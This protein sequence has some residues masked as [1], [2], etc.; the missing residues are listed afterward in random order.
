MRLRVSGLAL[1]WTFGCA[2]AGPRYTRVMPPPVDVPD[3]A[4]ASGWVAGEVTRW[5]P[6][7]VTTLTTSGLRGFRTLR[8][9][10]EEVEQVLTPAGRTRVERSFVGRT[11]VAAEARW[12]MLARLHG[13]T[14]AGWCARGV[15]VAEGGGAEGFAHRT[16]YIERLL[17]VG[18]EPGGGLWGAWLEGLML[19]RV[20]WRM[21][22][23]VPYE[24]AVETPRRNH[25]DIELWD[26]DLALRP[27]PRPPG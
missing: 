23:W 20:G 14:V 11:P 15:R 17:V 18:D 1:A 21:L 19:T 27:A 7:V 12:H 26:C 4:L 10:H 9:H 16:V 3:H 8:L 24:A 6:G 25:T 13:S 5:L 22:P 2:S